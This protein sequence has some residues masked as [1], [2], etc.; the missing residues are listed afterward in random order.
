MW[1]DD[2]GIDTYVVYILPMLE[3]IKGLASLLQIL[4]KTRLVLALELHVVG[5][6]VSKRTYGTRGQGLDAYVQSLLSVVLVGGGSFVR[7]LRVVHRGGSLVFL[8]D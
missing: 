2:G 7:V 6:N 5:E 4:L 3:L 1:K 8:L